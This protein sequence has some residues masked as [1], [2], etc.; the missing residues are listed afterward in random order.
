MD[1]VTGATVLVTNL[2]AE[3]IRVECKIT[4]PSGCTVA[5]ATGA[6]GST[7]DGVS[8]AVNPETPSRVTEEFAMAGR[9]DG[10]A[11]EDDLTPVFG[12]GE[13]TVYRFER[14]LGRECPCE[15]V[16]RRDCPVVDVRARGHDLYLTFH[17][18]SMNRL[19]SVVRDLRDA[20]PGLSVQ[21]LLRTGAESPDDSAVLVD[22]GVLTARQR[23]V[24]ETAQRMGYFEHPKEANASEVAEAIDISPS[25]FAEHLAAAQGKLLDAILDT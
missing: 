10:A 19:Q 15:V 7:T 21:R 16:E 2:M 1:T 24:L 17:A 11:L 23:E 9:P 18:P 4:E 3:G 5:A 13:E 8:K 20:F 22:R 6:A 25:T 14:E 12:Y